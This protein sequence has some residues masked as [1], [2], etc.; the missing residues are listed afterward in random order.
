M[1]EPVQAGT[2]AP[3]EGGAAVGAAVDGLASKVRGDSVCEVAIKESAS[4]ADLKAALLPRLLSRHEAAAAA[5]GGGAGGGGGGEDAE[6]RARLQ[7][8]AA[9][10]R[11]YKRSGVRPGG[12][13][14]DGKSLRQSLSG[15]FDDKQVAVQL[16]SSPE[17]LTDETLLV[18]WT[19]IAPPA[20]APSDGADA[21]ASA[22]PA[23]PPPAVAAMGGGDSPPPP[24]PA[25]P[26]PPPPPPAPAPAAAS[27]SGTLATLSSGSAETLL[28]AAAACTGVARGSL[29]VAKPPTVG[30]KAL[31]PALLAGLKWDDPKLLKCAKVG[32]HPLQLRDGDRLLFRDAAAFAAAGGDAAAGRGAPAGRGRG[33]VGGTRRGGKHAPAHTVVGGRTGA[34]EAG[35]VIKTFLDAPPAPAPSS[36]AGSE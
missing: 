19:L 2:A 29:S 1:C 28:A 23:E 34:R 36:G 33:G 10:L 32:S 4:V 13:L 24:L 12:L 11:L 8:G 21:A 3:A 27:R 35:V 20:T 17:V 6:V 26:P 22:A 31:T 14:R 18:R 25:P 15:G 5:P 30:S 9:A 7:A 16:L